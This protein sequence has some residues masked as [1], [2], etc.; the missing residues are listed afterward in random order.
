MRYTSYLIAILP[1]IFSCRPP[2]EPC[3]NCPGPPDTIQTGPFK[4]LWQIPLN[5]DTADCVSMKPVLYNGNVLYSLLFYVDGYESLRMVD[6]KTGKS[7]WSWEPIWPGE[8]LWRPS[9]FAKDNLFVMTHWGPTYC[10]DMNSGQNLWANNVQNGNNSGSPNLSNVGDFLYTEHSDRQILDTASYFVRANIYNGIWDT[11]FVLKIEDGYRPGLLPP[12]LWVAPQGD[13]ILI[14]QNRQWNFQASDGRVDLLAYNLST[15]TFEWS[16]KDFDIVGNSNLVTPF[17]YDN[18]VYLQA[19]K[20]L[21]CFDAATGSQLWNWAAPLSWDNLMQANL[22]AA[23]GKIFVKPNNESSL[24]GL[25]LNT[26]QIQ[27]FIPNAGLG[28]CH[29]VYHN[30]II[31]YASGGNGK[32]CAVRPS[33][34][35]VIWNDESPNN[36]IPGKWRGHTVFD[37]LTISPEL[38]C[39]FVSDHYFFM[40]IKLPE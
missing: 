35:E 26:G 6:E 10:V 14:F 8:T 13:S 12:S 38:N 27:V 7:V 40:A 4:V 37:D 11:L 33:T 16:V 23:E 5:P 34:Q 28:Q 18:K 15:R 24:Y 31:Y 2:E 19:E 20:K 22:I 25:N 3:I 17:I 29:M 9:R 1:F 30:G 32:L 39:L 36:Q 21:Y